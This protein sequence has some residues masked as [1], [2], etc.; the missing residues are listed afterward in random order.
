MRPWLYGPFPD[1][2]LGC[3]GLYLLLFAILA[4]AG[5]EIRAGQPT[6]LFPLI[7]M[8]AGTPHY[9]ATLL[10]VYERRHDRRG[11]VLF[12]LWATLAVAAT[13]V[14]G[15]WVPAAGV[16]LVTLYLTWSP[17]HYTGQ[18][19]GIAVM[20]LRR[21]GVELT[22][23][24]KRWVYASFVLSYA[25]VFVMLHGGD[26]LPADYASRAIRFQPLGVPDAVLAVVVPA[27]LAAQ[28]GALLGA[29]VRLLRRAEPR[30]LAPAGMLALTQ[31][32]WFSLP[33]GL[34][35]LDVHPARLEAIDFDFRTHY[36]MWI[37]GG[38][39]L[40]YLWV[41]SYYARQASDWSGLG[42]WYAKVLTA[43]AAVW[44]L[45]TVA[46]GPLGLGPLSMDL[47]LA[48]LVASA[49]NVHH[50]ILD[51]AIWKLRGRIAEVLIRNGTQS[52]GEVRHSR[53]GAAALR[54]VWL[55][56]A[57]GLILYGFQV[58]EKERLVRAQR[59]GDLDAMG[60]AWDRLQWVG[61][62][63][64]SGRTRLGFALLREGRAR[65][66]REQF[67][68]GLELG[69]RPATWRGL[70]E[71]YARRGRWKPAAFVVERGL[72]QF[73]DD[74]A[75]LT[76][77]ARAWRLAGEPERARAPLGRAAELA[78]EDPVVREELE[79]L[80]RP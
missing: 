78:P 72:E 7:A 66:A 36:F 33:F 71:S 18:N 67:R 3:G 43:G 61:L 68:R 48:I 62:D 14:A 23:D 30:A 25:L 2:L 75:L 73:P 21:A 49:V 69:P 12:S 53:W 9:G 29:A 60:A 55:T 39:F 74:V 31:L 59:R 32:L 28:L 15:L 46:L 70:A 35:F 5:P 19:Y 42:L 57:L 4:L 11:Y 13:F 47:G 26:D 45:P 54:A 44:S 64:V 17:W 80:E 6:I 16:F 79:M 65:D 1:L 50:F 24:D 38:H 22:G 10:R 34:R 63:E 56:C 52:V 37:A 41:T 77:G 40:Q 8:L 58:A 51:G 27:L 20:L 76:L